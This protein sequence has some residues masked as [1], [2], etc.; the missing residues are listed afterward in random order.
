MRAI[1]G[2]ATELN[3]LLTQLNKQPV[4]LGERVNGVTDAV[5][6]MVVQTEKTLVGVE[7]MLNPNAPLHYQLLEVTRE[8]SATARTMRSFIELLER[9]PESLFFGKE[10]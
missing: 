8:L 4:P 3:T 2:A 5:Q 1:Q 7:G 6:K 9:K 10:K